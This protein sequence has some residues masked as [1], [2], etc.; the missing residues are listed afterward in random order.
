MVEV[1]GGSVLIL[2]D[3]VLNYI[4]RHRG[5][6]AEKFFSFIDN[7][8]R[9]HGKVFKSF[10]H[11]YLPDWEQREHKLRTVNAK[12]IPLRASNKTLLRGKAASH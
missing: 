4:N 10:M 5:T 9:N 8:T 3:E 11:A 12:P 7:V 1:A 2:C 6:D